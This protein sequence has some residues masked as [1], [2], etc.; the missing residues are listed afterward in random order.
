M[1]WD[2]EHCVGRIPGGV[3]DDPITEVQYLRRCRCFR[4]RPEY[5]GGGIWGSGDVV[6]G[7]ME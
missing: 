1:E 5:K 6:T 3:W 7:T 4:E 2:F